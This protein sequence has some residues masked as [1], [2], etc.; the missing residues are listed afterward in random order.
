VL[1]AL[2]RGRS[3]LRILETLFFFLQRGIELARRPMS[4]M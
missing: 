1:L 2:D 4:L 3:Q